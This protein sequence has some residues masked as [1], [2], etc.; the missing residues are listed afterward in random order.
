M[1]AEVCFQNLFLVDDLPL[2]SAVYY[3]HY[4]LMF[5]VYRLC[6][7]FEVCRCYF[8]FEDD[9]RYPFFEGGHLLFFVVLPHP[10]KY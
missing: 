5:V 3:P 7:Y 4:G 1:D 6:C 2:V 10:E 8:S 9:L